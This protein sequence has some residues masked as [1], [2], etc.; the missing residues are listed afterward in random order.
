M[1]EVRSR[2]VPDFRGLPRPYWIL[3]IGTLLNRTGG[4]VLVFL[5]IYLT[6]VRGL[7]AAQAGYVVATFGLGALAGAPIGG[8][9]AD[10]LGRRPPLVVSRQE[11]DLAMPVLE[12]AL[13]KA[14]SA[15]PRPAV[16]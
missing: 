9:L 11:V 12:A 2:W 8:A 4:F 1:P 5:G 14:L 15:E 3:F 7:T 13:K 10:R 6:E 16:H